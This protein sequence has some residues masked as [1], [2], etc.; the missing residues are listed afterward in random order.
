MT[1]STLSIQ[2]EDRRFYI[3]RL[4]AKSPDYSH[5][6]GVIQTVLGEVG[7][8]VS[9]D[10]IRSDIEWLNRMGLVTVKWVGDDAYQVATATERGLD[11]AIGRAIVPGVRRPDPGE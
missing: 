5:N 2:A 11:A 8:R 1:T 4:L 9:R 3:L 10:V 6:N 7:H